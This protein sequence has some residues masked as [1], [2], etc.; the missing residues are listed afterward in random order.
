MADISCN[1]SDFGSAIFIR[2]EKSLITDYTARQK[3]EANRMNQF[4]K[5]NG[6]HMLTVISL[7]EF[8]SE[9]IEFG[10]LDD[11]RVQ[12][13]TF[14]LF[15]LLSRLFAHPYIAGSSQHAHF[16]IYRFAIWRLTS[17]LSYTDFLTET[18]FHLIRSFQR[19]LEWNSLSDIEEVSI[20]SNCK[21]RSCQC[22][23]M[24]NGKSSTK[25]SFRSATKK[26]FIM[27]ET[28]RRFL[29][30]IFVESVPW[31]AVSIVEFEARLKSFISLQTFRVKTS[32]QHSDERN[33]L[34]SWFLTT[35]RW[36]KT[37][38]IF[39]KEYFLAMA[40]RA[41]ENSAFIPSWSFWWKF[42]Y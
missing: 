27:H 1:E 25:S 11:L 3:P 6:K 34:S 14:N 12:Q 40:A 18:Q 29:K 24:F 2:D 10:R 38:K 20:N 15:A 31:W 19:I 13:Q 5:C 33:Y 30:V 32:Q 7:S 4:T 28:Q 9:K 17:M 23:L 16:E 22:N 37:H 39:T 42:Q 36:I 26:P 21:P 35:S 41:N 8:I